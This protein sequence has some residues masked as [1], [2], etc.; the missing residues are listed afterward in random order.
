MHKHKVFISYHHANDQ[1]YKESLLNMNE[2]SGGDIFINRS[3]DTGDIS[4]ELPDQTIKRKI[5]DDFLQDSTVTI[6]LVGTET[7]KRK[8]IDW[9][10]ASSMYNGKVNKQSGIIAVLLPDAN[11]HG[12]FTAGHVSHGERGKVHPE[13]NSWTTIEDRVEYE[14]RYPYLPDR[15]IDQL[16]ED[17]AKVSVVPWNKINDGNTLK[18]LIDV[19]YEDRMDCS[20]DMSRDL[21]KQDGT[22]RFV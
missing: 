12:Y 5:R 21:R 2:R 4:D 10:V 17:E 15:I 3:V 14:R 1:K 6:L 16:L 11:P 18:F 7:K 22:K 13:C 9:E 8:H 20:Y 19:A